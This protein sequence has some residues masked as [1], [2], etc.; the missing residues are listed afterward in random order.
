[1]IL[2][3]ILSNLTAECP[4]RDTLYWY[5]TV[6]STNT[7]A[8]ALARQGAP[9]GTVLVAGEQTG[10]RGRMGRS[11]ESRA[12]MGV[13]LSVIL[14]PGCTA[15]ELMHL[16]CAA[17]VAA[18]Q[19]VQKASGLEP[20][21]KWINDL[22]LHRKKLGGI[23][24]ELS[25]N[26]ATS[27]VDYAIVG[28]GLNCRQRPEDFPSELERI[29]TSLLA[30][31]RDI[32]PE[33]LTAALVE[34]LWQMDGHLLDQKQQL[35][36]TYRSRCITLGQEVSIHRGDTVTQGKAVDMDNDGALAVRLPDDSLVT[37]NSGEVSIRG[38]YGY[39]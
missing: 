3:E 2:T 31:G 21:L 35:M 23:L 13:Y 38:L 8:K 36:D 4:W 7:Q 10:G 33:I 20:G 26:P 30:A 5:D 6:D 22:V 28:I 34:A 17:G 1:M 29:A 27:A 37:V 9:H 18:C 32:S 24:T 16:T 19:A 15:G 25:V 11:F 39:I 12:G 14:R